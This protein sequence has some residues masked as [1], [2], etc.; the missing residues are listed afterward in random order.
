MAL[1]YRQFWKETAYYFIIGVVFINVRVG[2]GSS[3]SLWHFDPKCLITQGIIEPT[4]VFFQSTSLGRGFTALT[5]SFVLFILRVRKL[6]QYLLSLKWLL[7]SFVAHL[8]AMHFA[9]SV[10]I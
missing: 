3:S 5:G 1:L 2:E 6:D 9:V 7:C 10:S 4:V 8:T